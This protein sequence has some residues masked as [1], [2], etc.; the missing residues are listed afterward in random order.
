MI[1]AGPAGRGGVYKL[2]GLTG[3]ITST[4]L[5]NSATNGPGHGNVCYR[6]AGSGVGYLYVSDLE[7]GLIYR[8]NSSTLTTVGA[9]FNHG[10]QGRPNE[11]LSPIV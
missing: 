10:V 5:P 4:S 3:A 1:P 6:R 7:N 9:T 8:L 2:N 11:S